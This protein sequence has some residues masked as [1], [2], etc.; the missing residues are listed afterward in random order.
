MTWIPINNEEGMDKYSPVT[1][2]YGICFNELGEILIL[3]QNG[4]KEWTLPG[5]TVE[6]DESPRDTLK[7]E[8]N[9]EANV[10]LKNISLLG[11]QMVDDPNN[12]DLEHRLYYQA[13]YIAKID[14][15]LPQSPDPAKGRVHTR[16]F[17]P[18]NKVTDYVKWG[19]TGVAIFADAVKAH[20]NI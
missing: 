20:K 10:L 15:L 9:E 16:L 17:V 4:K 18:A 11:V 7:R 2:A 3:D 8:V 13:R 6:V 19:E 12:S 1:Q 5:G 14:R